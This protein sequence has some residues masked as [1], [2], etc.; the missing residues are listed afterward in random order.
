MYSEKKLQVIENVKS[1]SNK[2]ADILEVFIAGFKAG[3][4][5]IKEE[6]EIE[7]PCKPPK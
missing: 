5:S 6:L 3:K 1:M 7:S 4:K 2:E